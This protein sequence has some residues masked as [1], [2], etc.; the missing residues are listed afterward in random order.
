MGLTVYLWSVSR[1]QALCR[2][3]LRSGAEAMVKSL[4]KIISPNNACVGVV[5]NFSIY[6]RLGS[7]RRYLILDLKYEGE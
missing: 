3:R 7:M 4:F 1:P 6:C 5:L 2:L